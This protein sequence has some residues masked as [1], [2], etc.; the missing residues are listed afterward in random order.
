MGTSEETHPE[1]NVVARNYRDEYL[2]YQASEQDKRDRAKRNKNR[3]EFEREGRVSKH[4]G[5]DIDHK[6]GD[7]QDNARKNLRVMSASANRAKH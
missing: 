3:R 7:P 4:D 1:D 2:K 6:N 5:R